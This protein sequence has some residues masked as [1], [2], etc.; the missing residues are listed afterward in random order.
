MIAYFTIQQVGS[1]IRNKELFKLYVGQIGL[2]Q[3]ADGMVHYV[4][5]D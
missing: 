2:L 1:V 3:I 5:I 4:Q